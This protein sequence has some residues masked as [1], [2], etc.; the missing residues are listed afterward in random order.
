M[1]TISV[2]LDYQHKKG[3][4]KQLINEFMDYLKAPG[5]QKM[6]ILVDEDDSK[7]THFFRTNQFGPSKTLTCNEAFD[8]SE[9][10]V[11]RGDKWNAQNIISLLTLTRK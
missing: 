3:I 5:V 11:I 1:A 10:L 4:G 2:D 6:D 9:G 7:L 8:V